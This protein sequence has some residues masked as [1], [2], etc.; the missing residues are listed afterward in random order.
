MIVIPKHKTPKA[1]QKCESSYWK[2]THFLCNRS[3]LHP[4]A[5]S[6]DQCNF[7]HFHWD[8][9]EW[10]SSNLCFLPS[11]LFKCGK[12]PD[13]WT[14]LVASIGCSMAI[15]M[16]STKV[17]VLSLMW[18]EL[19]CK[20]L[21]KYSLTLHIVDPDLRISFV[22]YTSMEWMKIYTTLLMSWNS[23]KCHALIQ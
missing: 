21:W 6:E 1:Y 2:N 20:F 9:L 8:C 12:H 10:I 19:S 23:L 11:S 22:A 4:W 16:S 14:H 18:Q 17:I 5:F 15:Q 13:C 3:Y 7:Q